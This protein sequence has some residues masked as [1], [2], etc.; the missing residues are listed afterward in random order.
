M[1]N[2]SNKKEFTLAVF[3]E[4]LMLGILIVTL[5]ATIA[6]MGAF[7]FVLLPF[8]ALAL[9][10]VLAFRTSARK[11]VTIERLP[12]VETFK[13]VTTEAPPEEMPIPVTKTRERELTKVA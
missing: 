8:I 11:N 5:M 9:V 13:A 10:V 1:A 2:S 3:V 12:H 4:G 7:L 6:I